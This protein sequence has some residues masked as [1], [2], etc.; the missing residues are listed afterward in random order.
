MTSCCRAK[1]EMARGQNVDS[2]ADI[3]VNINVNVN[4]NVI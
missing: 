3:N 1:E 4:V 2:N